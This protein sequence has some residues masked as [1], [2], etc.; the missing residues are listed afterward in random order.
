MTLTGQ[1]ASAAFAVSGT[2]SVR[3]PDLAVSALAKID[4]SGV[5]KVILGK[6]GSLDVQVSGFSS[7]QVAAAER[8]VRQSTS[9]MGSV[10][11]GR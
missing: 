5:G 6:V 9:G 11:I 8:I 3:A 7:V 2:S 1:A 10:Q 4:I